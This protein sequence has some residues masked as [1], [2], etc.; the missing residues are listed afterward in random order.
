MGLADHGLVRRGDHDQHADDC[1]DRRRHEERGRHECRIRLPSTGHARTEQRQ[2]RGW[3]QHRH[4]EAQKHPIGRDAQREESGR[5]DHRRKEQGCAA[6]EH[7]P[8]GAVSKGGRCGCLPTCSVTQVVEPDD[9]ERKG[10]DRHVEHRATPAE[11]EQNQGQHRHEVGLPPRR[12]DFGRCAR[13]L[14]A[15]EQ[16]DDRRDHQQQLECVVVPESERGSLERFS[17]K[18]EVQCAAEEPRWSAGE[19]ARQ[20]EQ[21][22]AGEHEKHDRRPGQHDG[23]PLVD[24]L[25]AAGS[26]GHRGE[27]HVEETGCVVSQASRIVR[28]NVS[29]HHTGEILR[30]ELRMPQVIVGV[31]AE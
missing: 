13:T 29:P 7:E 22:E 23:N 28:A 4:E 15:P 21:R 19:A 1:D 27:P 6:G 25:P 14:D 16:A 9:E 8:T 31:G 26:K 18:Q 3:S 30:G 5:N 2:A 11:E 20:P 24:G 10:D 12:P 17:W